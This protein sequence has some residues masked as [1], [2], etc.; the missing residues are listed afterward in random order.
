LLASPVFHILKHS[1]S[2]VV[3]TLRNSG[4]SGSMEARNLRRRSLASRQLNHSRC[5]VLLMPA[6]L[7]LGSVCAIVLL[8]FEHHESHRFSDHSISPVRDLASGGL[9]RPTPA[10]LDVASV[11][12]RD[13]LPLILAH[14]HAN[15]W[16]PVV[17]HERDR[18]SVEP[19]ATGSR[20]NA[21]TARFEESTASPY[22]SGGVW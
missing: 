2:C 19:S 20:K 1:N 9:P 4:M 16:I 7:P 17:S 6:V 13:E 3:N 21:S 18:P 12:K 14:H 11:E 22:D 10:L 5:C 8:S 15:A